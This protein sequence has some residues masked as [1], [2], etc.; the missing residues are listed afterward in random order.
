[1]TCTIEQKTE[2]QWE[3]IPNG[4]FQD[5]EDAVEAATE[6]LENLDWTD[7]RIIETNYNGGDAV[8]LYGQMPNTNKDGW[9]FS[10]WL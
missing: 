3:P 1:M 5:I 10:G 8:H 2:Y 7:I 9:Y 4:E 6:L